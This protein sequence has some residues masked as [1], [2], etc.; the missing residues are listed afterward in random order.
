MHVLFIGNSHTYCND[1]PGMV[2]AL[3]RADDRTREVTTEQVAPG[4]CRLKQHWLDETGAVD[5]VKRGGWD[6][7]VLQ[8]NSSEPMM[9]PQNTR[10]YGGLFAR[11]AREVGARPVFYMTWARGHMPET[12]KYMTATYVDVARAFNAALAPA[13]EAWKRSLKRNPEIV[14]HMPDNCHAT[15]KGTYLAACVFHATLHGVPPTGLRA[16]LRT[17]DGAVLASLRRAEADALQNTARLAVRAYAADVT[18]D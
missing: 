12:Q 1:L 16:R 10:E 7:V 11:L 18:R 9:D 5:A 8:D 2:A 13:G 14:L 6:V 15:R 17:P 4:G 3:A